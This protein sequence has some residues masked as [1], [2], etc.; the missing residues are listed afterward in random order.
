MKNRIGMV[1]MHLVRTEAVDS[2][3]VIR[4]RRNC[5]NRLAQ[6]VCR[7]IHEKKLDAGKLSKN[8]RSIVRELRPILGQ[9]PRELADWLGRAEMG[10]ETWLVPPQC[11]TD[12]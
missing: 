6:F 3:A 8:E 9:G 12:H 1:G 10:A 5:M 11:A 4:K 7:L 2:V